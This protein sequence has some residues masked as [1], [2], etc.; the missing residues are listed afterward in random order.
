MNANGVAEQKIARARCKNSRRSRT[1]RRKRAVAWVLEIVSVRS[2]A[3]A[4][5]DAPGRP[6]IDRGAGRRFGSTGALWLAQKRRQLPWP[7][8]FWGR[9]ATSLERRTLKTP[10]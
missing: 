4:K 5:V 7:H 8:G 10:S 1:C 9:G 2:G 3:V 6:A